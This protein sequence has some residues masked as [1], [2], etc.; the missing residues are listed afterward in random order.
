MM[1]ETVEDF[2]FRNIFNDYFIQH[3]QVGI[4]QRVR[5]KVMDKAMYKIYGYNL[6]AKEI[7]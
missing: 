4:I 1:D 7:T 5:T 3:P 6:F 2:E